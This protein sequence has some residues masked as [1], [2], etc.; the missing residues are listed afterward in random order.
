MSPLISLEIPSIITPHGNM[1]IAQLVGKL[2]NEKRIHLT[3][4]LNLPGILRAFVPLTV[5]IPLTRKRLNF[6]CLSTNI[7]EVLSMRSFTSSM[8]DFLQKLYG[9][10][11]IGHFQNLFITFLPKEWFV[12]KPTRIS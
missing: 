5:L 1:W 11:G 8:L 7:L 12:M 4:L 3:P 9:S 2:L 10:A 6:G